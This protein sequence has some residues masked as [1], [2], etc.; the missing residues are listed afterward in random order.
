[1]Y[2]TNDF[3]LSLFIIFSVFSIASALFITRQRNV[4]YAS[5]GLA[6][7]GIATAV[8][9]A[10]LNPSAYAFYSAFH[11]FLYV[12]SA[13]VFLSIS[14]VVF[15]G[16]EVREVQIPWAGL[17]ALVVGALTFL[18]LFVTFTSLTG[19]KYTPVTFNLVQFANT[20]LQQYWFPTVILVIALLTTMI[21]ALSLAR[22][23]R[24]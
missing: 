6:F 5:V 23:E 15:R 4:F 18:G 2:Q 24:S 7:L 10:L 13:V 1:M 12:G 17:V 19:I 9:I 3:Q 8:L 11:L 21:E 14:L 20:F 22:G 16:L